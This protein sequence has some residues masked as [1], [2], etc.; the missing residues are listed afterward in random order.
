MYVRRWK[1]RIAK[2]V[3]KV[4]ANL[5]FVIEKRRKQ[6]KEVG[7][8]EWSGYDQ[9]ISNARDNEEKYLSAEFEGNSAWLIDDDVR[10][11]VED[12]VVRVPRE[13]LVVLAEHKVRAVVAA[14]AQTR[15]GEIGHDLRRGSTRNRIARLGLVHL[16]QRAQQL[17]RHEVTVLTLQ[18]LVVQPVDILGGRFPLRPLCHD[19][20]GLLVRT[21]IDRFQIQ[22]RQLC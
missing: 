20:L 16:G 18:A 8:C 1:K 5:D 3:C 17:A 10:Q 2:S 19:F 9:C 4:R 12:S 21:P 13:H 7:G 15:T 6:S 14:S 22:R 11:Y